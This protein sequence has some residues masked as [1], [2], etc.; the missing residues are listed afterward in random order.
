M[1]SVNAYNV[2]TEGSTN[3]ATNFKVREFKSDSKIVLIHHSLP[4]ALQMIREKVGK[5]VNL[6][7]AYRTDAH[8]IRV[9]GASNSYHLYGMAAD[10]YVNGMQPTDLAKI[11]DNM[12]P[13]TY[14]VIAYPKKG[15]VHFD[16]RSQKYRAMNNGKEVKVDHF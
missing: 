10:I 8:N 3:V 9:G 5:A 13:T 2:N 14:G 12:F 7:C 6:T 11:I 1:V 16:V 15:I 4:I